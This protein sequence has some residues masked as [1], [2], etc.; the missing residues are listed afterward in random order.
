MT[1]PRIATFSIDGVTKYGGVVDGG[2]VD[3]SARFGKEFPTLREAIAAGALMKLAEDAARRPPDHALEAIIGCRQFPRRKK[4]SASAST[5]PTATPNI[6][7]A[8]MRRNIQHVPSHA[9]IFRRTSNLPGSPACLK[10]A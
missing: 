5:I 10:P 2:M 3:L 9:A 4:S 6:K 7:T 1:P 8:R